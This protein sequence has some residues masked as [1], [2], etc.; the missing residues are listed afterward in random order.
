MNICLMWDWKD[1]PDW[2]AINRAITEVGG[3]P[4]LYE[5]ADTGGDWYGLV[6]SSRELS[7]KDVQACWEDASS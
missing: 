4:N 3:T 5:V 1:Q 7:A 6:V 2:D